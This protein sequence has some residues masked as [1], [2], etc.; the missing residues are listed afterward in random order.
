MTETILIIIGLIS[1]IVSILTFGI[2]LLTFLILISARKEPT[3]TCEVCGG[4]VSATFK[5]CPYCGADI[6]LQEGGVGSPGQ[7]RQDKLE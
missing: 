3:L 7:A 6:G 5:I 2:G 4:E 1:A